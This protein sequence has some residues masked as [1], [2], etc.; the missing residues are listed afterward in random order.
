MT[1]PSEGKKCPKCGCPLHDD[2]TCEVCSA[3][4]FVLSSGHEE[5]VR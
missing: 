3:V 2:G 1:M 4:A 5:K